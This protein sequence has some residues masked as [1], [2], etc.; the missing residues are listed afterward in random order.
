M[1]LISDY[2]IG[3][4]YFWPLGT[5]RPGA[6]LAMIRMIPSSSTGVALFE[7]SRLG[8]SSVNQSLIDVERQLSWTQ[9]L[10]RRDADF[11]SRTEVSGH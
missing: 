6:L 2:L 5:E 9:C 8:C 11:D 7:R 4:P 10:V 1:E 3:A